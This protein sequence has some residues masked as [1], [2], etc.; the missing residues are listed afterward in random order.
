MEEALPSYPEQVPSRRHPMIPARHRARAFTLVE[1]LVVISIIGVLMS[2]LL[3][4]V[5]AARETAR[6]LQCANNLH[7]LALA[8]TS[9]QNSKK[10]LPPYISAI[11]P[12][13][14]PAEADDELTNR[15]LASW[16]VMLFPYME[17]G[18]LWD[19]W[20][21]DPTPAPPGRPPGE[22]LPEM[23]LPQIGFLICPSNPPSGSPNPMSYIANTGLAGPTMIGSKAAANGVFQ[24]GIPPTSKINNGAVVRM[25]IDH[26]RDG[27]SNTVMLSENLIIPAWTWTKDLVPSASGME[28]FHYGFCWHMTPTPPRLINSKLPPDQ[29]PFASTVEAY[30]YARPSSYHPGGVNTMFC[31]AH[32]AFLID[33]I[34]YKVYRQLMTTNAEKS[35]DPTKGLILSGDTY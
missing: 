12:V 5:Q 25:T 29:P 20:Q 33:G 27:T 3:P 21:N 24:N 26:V 8:V 1:L 34:D 15:K 6:R 28:K 11:V 23:E 16:A 13:G 30:D 22:T 19:L 4:A 17:Q 31:D 7:Q 2:L 18:S 9:H 14:A 10:T 32:L 35:D